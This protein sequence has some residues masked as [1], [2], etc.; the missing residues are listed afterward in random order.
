MQYIDSI[1]HARDCCR[2]A[3][4]LL[5]ANR[6]KWSA[7]YNMRKPGACVLKL[8]CSFYAATI[9]VEVHPLDFTTNRGK[10]RFYCWDTAGQEKF[11]GGATPQ[12]LVAAELSLGCH[13]RQ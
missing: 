2:R 10:L 13:L 7:E 11:G 4:S 12:H 3:A 9:G 1:L 5:T 8:T 6:T